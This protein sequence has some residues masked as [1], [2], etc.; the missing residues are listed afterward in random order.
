MP[1]YSE[2][3]FLEVSELIFSGWRR[4][5]MGE[6]LVHYVLSETS[7]AESDVRS[8]LAYISSTMAD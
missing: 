6:A 3:V 1:G 5:L 4:G 7:V 2:E 8:I